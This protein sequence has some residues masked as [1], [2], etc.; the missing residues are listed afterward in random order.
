MFTLLRVIP[1][2]QV[3]SKQLPAFVVSLLIAEHYYRMSF[4]EYIWDLS[5]AGEGVKLHLYNTEVLGIIRWHMRVYCYL[6]WLILLI[7]FENSHIRAIC[8]C[9]LFFI[10]VL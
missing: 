7:L 3:L 4:I 8:I 9:Y 1:F 5:G 2:S 6:P 10:V